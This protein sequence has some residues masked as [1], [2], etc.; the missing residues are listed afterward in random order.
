MIRR[1]RVKVLLM[2]CYTVYTV[3]TDLYF[4]QIWLLDANK[5]LSTVTSVMNA[6][7]RLINLHN[8]P[9]VR[10]CQHQAANSAAI[11]SAVRLNLDYEA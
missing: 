9:R 8:A 4:R 10:S 3:C 1:S 7:L 6:R 11:Q 5:D 2:K